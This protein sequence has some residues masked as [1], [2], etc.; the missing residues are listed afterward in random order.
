LAVH[1]D[2][3]IKEATD[4]PAVIELAKPA[5]AEGQFLQNKMREVPAKRGKL[6]RV[7]FTVSRLMEFCTKRELAN[8][9]GHHEYDWPLVIAKEMVDN[10]LDACEEAGVAPV[11]EIEVR[12]EKVIISDNGPGIPA[13]VID[14][15]I[16]YSV[17]TSSREAYVSPTR[18]AQGN[19]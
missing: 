18:G 13:S 9:T 17:R 3:L 16:D 10:G 4:Q 8:R 15:V 2:C 11:I 1:F 12:G 7:P 6:T 19:A 14:G 5:P